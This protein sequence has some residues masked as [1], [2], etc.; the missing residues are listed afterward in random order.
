MSNKITVTHYLN[1]KLKSEIIDEIEKFPLYIRVSANRSNKRMRSILLFGYYSEIDLLEKQ[2]KYLID[3]ETK[4]IRFIIENESQNVNFDDLILCYWQSVESAVV[5]SI[6][7]VGKG[8]RFRNLLNDEIL[9]YI[10]SK[11]NLSLSVLENIINISDDLG[12]EVSPALLREID[13]DI[14]QNIDLKNR[15]KFYKLFIQFKD[16]FYKNKEFQYFEWLYEDGSLNFFK[17][18]ETV[19]EGENKIYFDFYNSMQMIITTYY[20]QIKKVDLR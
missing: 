17:F 11:T 6:F 4:F 12:M 9:K 14:I 10:K 3:R 15:I 5:R 1:K 16:K 18:I 2:N 13:I 7:N 8:K 20:D 19:A